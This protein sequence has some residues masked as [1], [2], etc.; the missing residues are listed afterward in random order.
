MFHFQRVGKYVEDNDP[1]EKLPKGFYSS[2]FYTDYIIDAIDKDA[3]SKKPWF[4]YLSFTAPHWPLHAPDEFVA[5]YKGCLLYTSPSPRDRQKS[6][7]P[8]SA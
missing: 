5:K 8:S 6:R 4:A 2:D 3:N 1:V 7:M